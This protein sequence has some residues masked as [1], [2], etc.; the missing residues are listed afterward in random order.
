MIDYIYDITKIK[1]I[2]RK[3]QL[4]F[5]RLYPDYIEDQTSKNRFFACYI[6]GLVAGIASYD[7][8]NTKKEV[9]IDVIATLPEFRG[10]GVAMKLIKRIYEETESLY[11]TLGFRL[12]AEAYLDLPNNKFWDKLAEEKIYHESPSGK[13]KSYYYYLDLSKIKSL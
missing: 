8:K 11:V 3:F 12:K 6:N 9:V 5:G 13:T 7:I 2:W 1:E 4:E 10:Q